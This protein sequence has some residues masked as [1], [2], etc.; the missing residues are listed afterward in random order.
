MIQQE[1][2]IWKQ[3]L[4]RFYF[5]SEFFVFIIAVLEFTHFFSREVTQAFTEQDT[6]PRKCSWPSKQSQKLVEET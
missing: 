5:H 4:G 3:K 1:H 2:L 6:N